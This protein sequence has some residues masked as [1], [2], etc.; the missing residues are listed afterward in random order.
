M[1][2]TA[3]PDPPDVTN[4]R[5]LRLINGRSCGPAASDKV[6]RGSAT[7]WDEFTWTALLAY[8]ANGKNVFKCGGTLI[9]KRYVLTAA[10]CVTGLPDG[11][12]LSGVRI[13]EHDLNQETDCSD[14]RSEYCAPKYQDFSIESVHHHEEYRALTRQNDIALIRIKKDAVLGTGVATSCLPVENATRPTSNNVC[15]A[16]LS[17]VQ[18]PGHSTILYFLFQGLVVGWGATRESIRNKTMLR[19]SMAMIP[20]EECARNLENSGVELSHKQ[21]CAVAGRVEYSCVGD[22][23]GSFQSPALFNEDVHYFQY[24]VVSYGPRQCGTNDP[25]VYTKVAY[26]VKWIL[27]TITE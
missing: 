14:G 27:D 24:G 17:Q 4:H 15:I 2:S 12:V 16:S 26:Y 20:N 22:S 19:V 3:I 7:T 10:H 5:N 11:D 23:G 18:Q 21:F 1:N 9:N 25:V 6:L 8:T 13:G